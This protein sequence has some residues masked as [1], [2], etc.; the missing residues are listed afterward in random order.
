M[1]S[2]EKH[3]SDTLIASGII[4]LFY[5]YTVQKKKKKIPHL[6]AFCTLNCD[7][8]CSILVYHPTD[9][10]SLSHF[11]RLQVILIRG[12]VLIFVM[13]CHFGVT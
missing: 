9:A 2:K 3:D 11:L 1:K 8:S 7:F 13:S 6:I 12:N 4:V 10:I 5:N